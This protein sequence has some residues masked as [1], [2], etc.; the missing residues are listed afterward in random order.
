MPSGVVEHVPCLPSID[1]R[2]VLGF[3]AAS[4]GDLPSSSSSGWSAAPSAM[5]MTYFMVG[6]FNH[7]DAETQRGW[8]EEGRKSGREEMSR[9]PKHHAQRLHHFTASSTLL[10][11]S[12]PL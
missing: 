10:R 2:S 12:V 4:N 7:R 11:A 8:S 5:T 1:S 6:D 9:R 3:F